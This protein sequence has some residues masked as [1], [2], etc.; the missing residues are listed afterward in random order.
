MRI[1]LLF[2]F[3]LLP[4]VVLAQIESSK[5][6]ISK[7]E[8]SICECY[9]NEN[10]LN[11]NVNLDSIT[12]IIEKQYS[13]FIKDTAYVACCYHM[14]GVYYYNSNLDQSAFENNDKAIALYNKAK[15]L[16]KLFEDGMLWKSYN[17]IGLSQLSN[18]QYKES[19]ESFKKA[20]SLKGSKNNIDNIYIC[21]NLGHSLSKLGEFDK[22]IEF[23]SK[24]VNIEIED[25][26]EIARTYLYFTDILIQTKN[27]ENLIQSLQTAEVAIRYYGENLEKVLA[28]NYRGI[29]NLWLENYKEAEKIFNQVLSIETG[30]LELEA[31]VLN[32]LSI[33][34]NKQTKFQE[35]IKNL[36]SSIEILRSLYDKTK[37]FR[38]TGYYENLA[39]SY[40][41]LGKLKEALSNYQLAIIN[42]T[43]NFDLKDILKS[44]KIS[45]KLYVYDNINFIQYLDAKG[46]TAYQLYK[47]ENNLKY[48]DLAKETYE[49][50]FEFHG[51]LYDQITTRSSRLIQAKTIMPYIE[52]ALKVQY[53]YQQLDR[54]YESTAFKFMELNKASVLIQQI[55]ESKSLKDFI[56]E[57][58]LLCEK[59]L[60]LRITNIERELF[61]NQN[62][63]NKRK[64][65][66]NDQLID[67]KEEYDQLLY[68][69]EVNFPNYKNL[70]YQKNDTELNSIQSHLDNETAIIEYFV[71]DNTIYAMTIQK[72]QV[73]FYE[74][75]KSID[76][77][78]TID[79]FYS[80]VAYNY[81]YEKYAPFAN[82][83]FNL[84]VEKPIECLDSS[85]IKN[86]QIIPDGELN[87][88]PFAALLTTL[89]YSSNVDYGNLN[90]LAN[91]FHI[92]YAYS[93]KLLLKAKK[94]LKQNNAE[95]EL[96][97]FVPEDEIIEK[98]CEQFVN[99]LPPG[100]QGK[101][102]KQPNCKAEDFIVNANQYKIVNII[103]HGTAEA[104]SNAFNVK[105]KFDGGYL[106]AADIYNID[107]SNNKLVFFTA[108]Q[109][110]AGPNKKGEG[111][112]SL[113]R[114]FTYAG[115]PALIS[116]LWRVPAESTCMITD[117]FFKYL[118]AGK[119]F[120]EVLWEAQKKY[121]TNSTNE[122]AHP[123]YWAGI[124]PIGKMDKIVL[125]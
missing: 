93:T 66:I 68:E 80:A 53:E 111:V 99:N 85:K 107:L 34:K 122:N 88:I 46:K 60:R 52:N 120:D 4:V 119:S 6:V 75:Q 25:S 95:N 115:S 62:Q 9:E 16:R 24:A 2:L 96:A 114:A 37:D 117:L 70:K 101:F 67:L 10:V 14:L 45:D 20:Y 50:A 69:W 58:E 26:V 125:Q 74:I 110:Q 36:N 13:Y 106:N 121:I 7:C 71:G 22:A 112:M 105:L 49:T 57:D 64:K 92:S 84:I 98:H 31:F 35:A 40:V 79:S 12:N 47:K 113:S 116:T 33:I 108:C 19:I 109:T 1:K 48:L 100:Y 102:F 32:N 17:N 51:R 55:T 63:A 124:I 43:N 15:I 91:K 28:L 44:P 94:D 27:T 82:R 103:T 21:R 81:K 38:Y 65:E 118:K 5:L 90:Y 56:P 123:Y 104:T 18:H 61:G 3:Q 39:E 23:V 97:R 8:D 54:A 41:G 76:W 83:L 77:K 59:D 30:D 78:T 86:I 42:S 89:D 72:E 29:A 87:K 73:D 11:E